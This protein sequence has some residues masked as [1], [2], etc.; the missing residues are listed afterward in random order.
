M[1]TVKSLGD[2]NLKDGKYKASLTFQCSFTVLCIEVSIQFTM[3]VTQ[4]C[5]FYRSS[6]L[7]LLKFSSLCILCS[8][9]TE[10][11]RHQE[12]QNINACMCYFHICYFPS[13]LR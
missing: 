13:F 4:A 5:V 6:F 7:N 10:L 11:E 1:R 12:T 3:P 2:V 9:S 8:S